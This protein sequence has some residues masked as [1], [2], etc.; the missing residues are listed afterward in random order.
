MIVVPD[1]E[2]RKLEGSFG[3]D[4]RCVGTWNSDGV[5]G[6][7]AVS[8]TVL[9]KAAQAVGDPGL[10]EALHGLR[11]SPDRTKRV[12]RTSTDIRLVVRSEDRQHISGVRHICA[13]GFT[14][15]KRMTP[16]KTF[17]PGRRTTETARFL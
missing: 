14:A 12:H 10:L 15:R 3:P 5:F 4:A 16:T 1:D 7:T 17:S 6:Y 13:P 9:E 11:R 8:V 2:L